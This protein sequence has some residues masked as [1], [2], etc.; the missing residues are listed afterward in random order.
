MAF[1]WGQPQLLAHR[2]GR[3]KFKGIKWAVLPPE[4][5][6]GLRGEGTAASEQLLGRN[7]EHLVGEGSL[8]S[9]PVASSA[10]LP[11]EGSWVS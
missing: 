1:A 5:G 9:C 10:S 3:M 8:G 11:E 2:Y 4:L 6:R 7:G